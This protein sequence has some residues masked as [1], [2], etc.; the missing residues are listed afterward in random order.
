[1]ISQ[2]YC[3]YEAEENA[4]CFVFWFDFLIL[5][6]EKGIPDLFG[7]PQFEKLSNLGSNSP[8]WL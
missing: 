2:S 7:I 1:M 8:K 6:I 4:Y 5:W 3:L